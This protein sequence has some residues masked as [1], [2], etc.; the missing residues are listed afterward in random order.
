MVDRAI[1][2]GEVDRARENGET[3][4]CYR[5]VWQKR[6]CEF[7]EFFLGFFLGFFE[8]W[9]VCIYERKRTFRIF[10]LDTASFLITFFFV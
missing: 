6:F 1:E 7:F 8:L 2:N 10:H 5:E 4:K 9:I 3:W